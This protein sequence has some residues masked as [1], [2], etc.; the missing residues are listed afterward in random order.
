MPMDA[1]SQLPPCI[2][3]LAPPPGTRLRVIS[4]LHLGHVRSE[5]PPV[6]ELATLLEGVNILVVAGD[7]TE[8]REPLF[9]PAG[10]AAMQELRALCREHGVQLICLAGNHDPAAGPLLLSLWGGRVAIMHGH[11]LYRECSPW[12]WEYLHNKQL[13]RDCIASLPNADHSLE[14]RLELSSRVCQLVPAKLQQGTTC[15]FR[16]LRGFIHC[17][18][19]PERPL[20][21][22][23]GWLTLGRR[24]CTF[25]RHYLP[26]AELLILGHFHRSGRWQYGRRTILNTGAW[27]KHATPM[28]AD[29]QD[30]RLLD[31]RP[32][33][34][35][36]N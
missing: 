23:W 28:L 24:A 10:E 30:G 35:P 6:A 11:A 31:Y 29:L 4:D 19:P 15:R 33:R 2:L 18:L 22:V 17:F 7:A 16:W 26:E 1:P 12:G 14:D 32:A 3:R 13:F 9:R 21:I 5:A 36:K 27:Y 34:F 25:A 20:R 8:E